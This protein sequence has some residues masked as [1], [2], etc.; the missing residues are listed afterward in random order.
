MAARRSSAVISG[1]TA[2]FGR[3][4]AQ[5][6]LDV[7]GRE[8]ACPRQRRLRPHVQ[9]VEIAGPVGVD[10]AL[11]RRLQSVPRLGRLLRSLRAATR[12]RSARPA[13]MSSRPLR[14]GNTTAP[15]ESIASRLRRSACLRLR[16]CPAA[17][18][19]VQTS[20]TLALLELGHAGASPFCSDFEYWP[21]SAQTSVPRAPPR[22]APAGWRKPRAR[23]R[24][25]PARPAPAARARRGVVAVP[26]RPGPARAASRPGSSWRSLAHG[27]ARAEAR[28]KRTRRRL[29]RAAVFKRA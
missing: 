17:S 6:P 1:A 18:R 15:A 27:T 14:S 11:S 21:T 22:A 19:M 23:Q 25:R 4:F 28:P 24:D 8:L 29:L 3:G 7:V 9:V 2:G 16:D 26:A 20:V 5:Q 12:A 13:G 10:S